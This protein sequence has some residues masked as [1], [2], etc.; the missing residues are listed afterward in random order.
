MPGPGFVHLN[1][2]S[3]YSLLHGAMTIGRLAELAKKDHQPAL[4]L[5]D[6]DNMFGALEFSEKLAG[7]GIQPIVGCAIAVDFADQEP[8]SRSVLVH[9]ARIVLLAAREEGYRSLMRLNSRAFLETPPHQAPHIKFDWLK[10]ESDGLIALTGGPSGPISMAVAH[11]QA[12]VAAAR[13]DRL[14]ALFG[15]RLYVELQRHNDE[16]ERAAERYLLDIAYRD[17]LPLVAANEPYFAARSDFEAHDALLCISD[18]AMLDDDARRRLT[19]EH[20]FKTR[21][22][23]RALFADLPEATDNSVAIA[24]RCS[25]R[26]TTRKPILPRFTTGDMAGAIRS[27][28][29]AGGGKCHLGIRQADKQHAVMKER[30]HHRQQ[31][32]LRPGLCRRREGLPSNFEYWRFFDF[33]GQQSSDAR[34]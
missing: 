8:G 26:P 6:A 24:L 14:S 20:R 32:P 9:P 27:T 22:E 34:V 33:A 10:G 28:A 11:D 29:T 30:Q 12:A 15:D 4:A 18:G 5:T 13:C 23:M 31:L 2:R 17:S 7:Y 16:A 19:P 25:Y 3:S 21:A 1:V